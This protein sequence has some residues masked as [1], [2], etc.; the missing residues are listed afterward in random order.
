MHSDADVWHHIYIKVSFF[1]TQFIG[2][3]NALHVVS[4]FYNLN[5]FLLAFLGKDVFPKLC[6]S[7]KKRKIETNIGFRCRPRKPSPRVNG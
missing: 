4:H 6:V 1:M 5:N 2:S 3:K 7:L